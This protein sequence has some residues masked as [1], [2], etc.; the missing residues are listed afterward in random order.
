VGPTTGVGDVENTKILPLPGLELRPLGRSARSQSLYRQRN[1]PIVEAEG[2]R[3]AKVL[4][5]IKSEDFTV[6]SG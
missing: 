1:R 5:D 2:S 6:N 4:Q 3:L